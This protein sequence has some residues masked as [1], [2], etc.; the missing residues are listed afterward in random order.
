MSTTPASQTDYAKLL[1]DVTRA[2]VYHLPFGSHENIIAGAEACGYVVFRVDLTQA[3]SKEDLLA[4]IGKDMA[5]PEWFGYNWDALADSLADLAWRPAE[6]YLVLLEHC[7]NLHANAGNDLVNALQIFENAATEWR[8]RGI[9]LWCLVD[10]QADGIAW[11][12][13]L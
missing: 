9:A 7:D 10:M 4:A 13:G 2:G 3:K 1:S 5:F 11:L 8:D 6:G 12:P